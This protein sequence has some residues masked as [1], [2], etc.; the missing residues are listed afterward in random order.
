[1]NSYLSDTENAAIGLIDLIK[2]LND[3]LYGI[4]NK[5]QWLKERATVLQEFSLGHQLEDDC[6]IRFTQAAKAREEAENALPELIAYENKAVF[7]E[8]ALASICGALLQVAKQGMSA[9]H[10]QSKYC[11]IGRQIIGSQYLATV[12]WQARNQSIHFEEG[13]DKL[14]K[15]VIACFA[16]LEKEIGPQFSLKT[17]RF[18]NMAWEIVKE[19]QWTGYDIYRMDMESLLK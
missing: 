8:T 17:N 19:L 18:K 15:P 10:G 3:E 7:N 4:Y 16:K 6:I 5:Y 9:T 14:Y 11:P 2:K 1:V 13:N 12:V